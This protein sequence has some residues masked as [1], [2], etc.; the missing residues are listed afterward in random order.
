MEGWTWDQHLK[1]SLQHSKADKPSPCFHGLATPNRMED[2]QNPE[3]SIAEHLFEELEETAVVVAVGDVSA[4]GLAM[5][6]ISKTNKQAVN[7]GKGRNR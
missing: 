6:I 1:R 3:G 4:E 5:A 7:T 2:A